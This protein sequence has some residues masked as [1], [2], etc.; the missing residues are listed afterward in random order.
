MGDVTK[1]HTFVSARGIDG[2]VVREDE[3]RV[4]NPAEHAL[5]WVTRQGMAG[6]VQVAAR[7]RLKDGDEYLDWTYTGAWTAVG[8]EP[9]RVSLSAEFEERMPL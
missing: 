4:T 7:V 1:V 6:T 5:A 9:Y 2:Q 3:F 8:D